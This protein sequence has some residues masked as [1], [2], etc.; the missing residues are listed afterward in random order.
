MDF[1][2]KVF[3]SVAKNQSFTKASRELF[4]SQPA[5]SKHIQ[6][7]E[8]SYGAPLFERSGNKIRLT[9]GGELLLRHSEEITAAYNQLEYEMQLLKG[10]HSGELRLGA[11]TTIA[12]YVLPTLLALFTEKFPQVKISLLNG[13][14]QE[15]EKALLNHQIQLGMVEGIIRQPHLKYTDYL[16]DE[17][18][19]IVH[20]KSKLAHLESIVLEHLT[21]LPLVLRE[22]GS[23]TLDVLEKALQNH[24]LKLSDLNIRMQLGSTESIK[25]FLDNANCM[26]IVSIRS[27][28]KD[29]LNGR[30]KVVE[31]ENLDLHRTLSFVHLHGTDNGLTSLFF[32]FADRY[33]KML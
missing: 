24:H 16:Q 31:I 13:N 6:E 32:Q 5:V 18:V 10:Q 15:V 26:G 29:L 17:L 4:L 9:I 7:L 1:R 3:Q 28:S 30:F 11:S 25:S 21:S 20:T 19:A 12:Q 27:I 33:K 14:S 23:G 22:R 8:K 2:L